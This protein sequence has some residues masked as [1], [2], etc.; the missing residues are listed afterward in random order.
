MVLILTDKRIEKGDIV[1]MLEGVSVDHKRLIS[2][3]CGPTPMMMDIKR[4]L[5]EI[6]LDEKNIRFESWW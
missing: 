1:R 3:L 4:A 6:G 5:L 2:Y